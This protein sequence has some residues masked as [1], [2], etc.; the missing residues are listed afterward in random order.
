[1]IANISHEPMWAGIVAAAGKCMWLIA[2][3]LPFGSS[4][5]IM[6]GALNG[7]RVE[8]I[9]CYASI[10]RRKLVAKSINRA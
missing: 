9:C 2:Q 4:R 8:S 5:V 7:L 10:A 1:M 3:S 6:E